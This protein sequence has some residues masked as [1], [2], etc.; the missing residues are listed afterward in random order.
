MKRVIVAVGEQIAME[1][2]LMESITAI[3]G[4]QVP[5]PEPAPTPEPLPPEPAPTPPPAPEPEEPIDAEI[6]DLVEQAR[7]HYEKAQENLKEGD[8]A[9]FGEEWDAMEAVLNEL[10][11]L[12][13]GE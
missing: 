13:A 2:T 11:E 6:M 8:W 9:G 12:A 1:P 7:Q 10:A 4:T 3:F 5:L